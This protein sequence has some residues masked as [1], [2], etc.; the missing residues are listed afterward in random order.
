MH[1]QL[2]WTT[3]LL[4]ALSH[5]LRRD[6]L[7]A[8][9]V[10]LVAALGGRS[11]LRQPAW[12]LRW[13]QRSLRLPLLGK[14]ILELQTARFARTLSILSASAVP[15]VEAMQIAA[16]V[17]GNHYARRQLLEA[18]EQ[19]RKG[20]PLLDALM[21]TDPAAHAPLVET[22]RLEAQTAREGRAA[23][24]AATRVEFF[25]LQRGED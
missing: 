16:Q 18:S 13:D 20:N 10:L 22:L 15:L 23:R 4:I 7:V 11:L 21:Q 1:Q 3:A 5:A 8:A 14:V 19:V 2:P 17:L 25:T 12:R 24:A 6:G 9:T